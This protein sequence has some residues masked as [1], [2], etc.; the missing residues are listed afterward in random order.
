[1]GIIL[2]GQGLRA[3]QGGEVFLQQT[4]SVLCGTHHQTPPP[5]VALVEVSIVS[6][7][8]FRGDSGH[9]AAFRGD[10]G[11]ICVVPVYEWHMDS[12]KP[13]SRAVSA[14]VSAAI[15]RWACS[16]PPVPRWNRG[17]S[18][19]VDS[20]RRW[21][22]GGRTVKGGERRWVGGTGGE[23]EGGRPE[24]VVAM[25]VTI[26]RMLELR[27]KALDVLPLLRH[28][29]LP[30]ALALLH[31]LLN[32]RTTPLPSD[33]APRTA[34]AHDATAVI[35]VLEGAGLPEGAGWLRVLLCKG[36]E[37]SDPRAGESEISRNSNHKTNLIRC[38]RRPWMWASGWG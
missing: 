19:T 9:W 13:W 8:R 31:V 6:R 17:E 38:R 11:H 33:P 10:S 15:V 35:L 21:K 27:C 12:P 28:Q 3:K 7:I 26:G 1:M 29:A 18:K 16:S 37:E 34:E 24:W 22:D 32:L 36:R 30:R 20:G 25:V 23:E 5:V 4:Y 14:S 2:P